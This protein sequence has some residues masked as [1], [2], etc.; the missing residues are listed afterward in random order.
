M[1]T[2]SY[3]F[4]TPKDDVV[5][6]RDFDVVANGQSLVNIVDGQ[7]HDWNDSTDVVVSFELE[8]DWAEL[9]KGCGFS[10]DPAPE[11]SCSLFWKSTG[12][13]LHGSS[14]PQPIRDG[15]NALSCDLPGALLGEEL[16]LKP[17]IFLERNP[18]PRRFRVSATRKSSRIWQTAIKVRLE[19]TGS[20]FPVSKVDFRDLGLEPADALW[21]LE[22]SENLEAHFSNA[23]RL[24]LNTSHPRANEYLKDPNSKNQAEFGNFLRADVSAQLLAFT[25]NSDL[26]DLRR[27]AEEPGTLAEGLL[28]VHNTY[29]PTSSLEVNREIFLTNPG[30][31]S[32]TTLARE[33]RAVKKE[34]SKK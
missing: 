34:K 13:G 27:T 10:S 29:F 18:D 15:I 9:T 8:V 16:L 12:S 31:I 6:V 2:T 7:S 22:I 14:F 24:Y 20:Q 33:F 3:G 11:F 21:K 23:V 30:F 5:R 26:E 28:E 19:G 32:A 17:T 25:Y 4:R 1:A